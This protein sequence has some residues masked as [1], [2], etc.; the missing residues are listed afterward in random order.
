MLMSLRPSEEREEI[1]S[2]PSIPA[3]R[4]SSGWVIRLSTTSAAAPV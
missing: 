1:V 2:T 4:S 3:S